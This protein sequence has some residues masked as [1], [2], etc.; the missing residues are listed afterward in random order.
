MPS[1]ETGVKTYSHTYSAWVFSAIHNK[2]RRIMGSQFTCQNK[3]CWWY[4]T[5][6]LRAIYPN[7]TKL[8]KA[9]KQTSRNITIFCSGEKWHKEYFIT[10]WPCTS[11]ISES[12]PHVRAAKAVDIC[13]GVLRC[14]NNFCTARLL[15]YKVRLPESVS[16]PETNLNFSTI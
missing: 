11:L 13:C 1:T 5:W 10:R 3:S 2:D 15:Q 8:K 6:N 7:E 14:S 12:A 9:I 4:S 16:N